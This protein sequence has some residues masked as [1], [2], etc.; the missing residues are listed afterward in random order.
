MFNVNTYVDSYPVQAATQPD[1]LITD[2]ARYLSTAPD[3]VPVVLYDSRQ[4]Y[5]QHWTIRLLAPQNLMD[6]LHCNPL[7]RL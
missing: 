4:F 6:V 3:D 7:Q 5:L 2:V 1:T